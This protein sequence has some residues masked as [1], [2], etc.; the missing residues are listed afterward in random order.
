MEHNGHVPNEKARRWLAV[1]SVPVA[2]ALAACGGTSSAPVAHRQGVI[3]GMADQCSGPPGQPAHQVRA[4]AYRGRRIVAEQSKLGSFTYR[5]SLSSGQ[6]TVTTD[7][8]Y[9]VPVNVFLRP[10]QLVHADLLSSCN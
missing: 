9:V 10:A 6:Y 2:V 7:Q 4:I 1:T 8:S 5:F 3:T